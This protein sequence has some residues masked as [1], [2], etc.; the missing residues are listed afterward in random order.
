MM[1]ELALAEL[2][3]CDRETI[4]AW[5]V[6]FDT[7][8][9]KDT[10]AEW[11][12]TRLPQEH[13]LR[14]LAVAEMVAIDLEHHWQRG[15]RLTLEA[16]LGKYPELGSAKTVP[17]ELVFAEYQVRQQF[18]AAAELSKFARR[19]P[20]Q[21]AELARRVQQAAAPPSDAHLSHEPP[22]VSAER[23][24]SQTGPSGDTAAAGAN[25][26]QR[27]AGILRP[28]PHHQ[29]TRRGRDGS[30][31]LGPRHTTGSSG[32]LE[33]APFLRQGRSTGRRAF[34]REARAAATIQHANLCPVY[35]AGQ[36]GGVHYLTMAYIE[37]HLLS[38][39]IRPGKPTAE[40]KAALVVR[41]AALA[42]HERTP[43]GS[44][45]AT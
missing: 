30:R 18:G 26:R 5:L 24:T 39:Y 33:G 23:D 38:E 8:W 25:G 12:T 1:A 22:L 36:I 34:L 35:D 32:R 17:A 11:V 37:G 4:E 10:L 15:N 9:Q 2:A 6:A 40:R 44:S 45:I 42:L 31:V 14:P 29:E 7:A 20:R 27:S 16:Y 21:T 28:I 19:F 13:P 3:D 43:A 41:T